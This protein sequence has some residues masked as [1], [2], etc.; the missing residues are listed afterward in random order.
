MIKVFTSPTCKYCPMVKEY[1]TKKGVKYE[2]VNAFES[3]EYRDL[4]VRTVP[5]TII[6]DQQIM[7]WN[8]R[9]LA[10]ALDRRAVQ[11]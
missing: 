11:E 10:Q 6:G 4:G 1:L 5:V 9:Q 2:E 3:E 7:G 8:I